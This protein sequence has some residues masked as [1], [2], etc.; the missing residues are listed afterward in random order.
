M[1]F[2]PCGSNTWDAIRHPFLLRGPLPENRAMKITSTA[3]PRVKSAAKLRNP[4]ERAEQGRFAI[5]GLREI[6]RALDGEIRVLEVYHCAEIGDQAE[7]RRLLLRLDKTRAAQFEVSS[8]VYSVLAYG[9]RAEGLVAVAEIPE[10][11]LQDF[12]LPEHPLVAVLEGVEKPGNVGAV[13]RSADGAGVSAVIVAGGGS[14]LYNANAIRAS[15]GTIFTLPVFAASTEETIA[16]LRSNKLPIF[17]AR[18]D[19]AVDYTACDYS[20]PCAVVL[21]SE[22]DGL[23]EAWRGPDITAI[24]LPMRGAADSLNVSATA[25][26]LFYEALRQRK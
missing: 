25:A 6:G 3:N 10:R 9:S 26:V 12:K 11:R 5:N 23:T 17:A 21:G 18:V 14:D 4:R 19:G 8:A 7:C 20:Q 24:R 15:L 16:W 1:N 22:A 2:A 13:L